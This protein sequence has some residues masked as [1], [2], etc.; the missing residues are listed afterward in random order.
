MNVMNLR[1][2]C[3]L[4]AWL[5]PCVGSAAE[6]PKDLTDETA[7]LEVLLKRNLFYYTALVP[8]RIDEDT[9][10]ESVHTKDD[11]FGFHC[12]IYTLS[13][14]DLP[15]DEFSPILTNILWQEA[16]RTPNLKL[17]LEKGGTIS[18]QYEDKEGEKFPEILLKKE[19]EP[20]KEE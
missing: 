10:M 20:A 5:L 4:I 19:A 2:A 14:E 13:K 11:Q 7:T 3:F 15:W 8:A 9:R 1:V 18:Y 17:L 16:Q 12:V 6:V